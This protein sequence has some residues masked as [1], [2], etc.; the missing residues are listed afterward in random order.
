MD[1]IKKIEE[2]LDQALTEKTFSLDI[3]NKI[4]EL[5]DGFEA[6]SKLTDS[7]NL[8]LDDTRKTLDATR[9]DKDVLALKLNAYENREKDIITKEK[10]LAKNLYELDFQKKR[11]DEL[12]ELVSLVFRN[13]RIVSSKSTS[14]PV[15]QNGYVSNQSGSEFETKTIE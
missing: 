2:I 1:N 9:K 8:Q 12:K 5:K 6:A 11:A 13:P 3:I 10:E 4:K 14:V 7:L 15:A